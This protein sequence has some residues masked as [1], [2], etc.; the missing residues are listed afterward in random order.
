MNQKGWLALFALVL[1]LTSCQQAGV[2]KGSLPVTAPAQLILEENQPLLIPLAELAASPEAYAGQLLEINGRFETRPLESCG[3]KLFSWPAWQM[4]EDDASVPAGGP[5]NLLSA[6]Q[7]AGADLVVEGYWRNQPDRLTCTSKSQVLSPWYFDV[8]RIVSPNPVALLSSPGQ[9]P[10]ATIDPNA[11]SGEP[12][13]F[14]TATLTSENLPSA[15]T[16]IGTLSDSE[17]DLLATAYPGGPGNQ[18]DS[19]PY[20]GL[21]NQTPEAIITRQIIASP[22]PTVSGQEE[23]ATA[24]TVV[25]PTGSP[26]ETPEAEAS[27]TPTIPSQDLGTQPLLETGSL[28]TG[29]LQAGQIHRWPYEISDPKT[30]TVQVAPDADL[31][32]TVNIVSAGGQLLVTESQLTAG[33]PLVLADVDL[34]EEGE[35]DI[36]VEAND[37]SAGNYAILVSDEESYSFTFQG[38]LAEGSMS[39]ASF[40]ADNDHFWMF[41]AEQGDSLRVEISPAGNEDLFFRLFDPQGTIIITSYNESPAGEKEELLDYLLLKEGL[42]SLLVGEQ[43]FGSASYS[44]IYFIE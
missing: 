21:E 1:L 25:T 12:D 3:G 14:P 34:L 7:G 22:T 30:I 35:Y 13:F 10:V 4:V 28:E 37:S 2:L 5:A 42:Y 8:V 9:E 39:S 41:S 24:T 16:E 43:N 15:T 33:Q 20:P 27:L 31:D 26:G 23:Q 11:S 17:G 29:S 38:L 18:E 32:L 40:E 36:L 44:A 6:L 19:S